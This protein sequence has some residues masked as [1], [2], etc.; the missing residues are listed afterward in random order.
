VDLAVDL[1][2]GRAF[3]K[4]QQRTQ[5]GR[6]ATNPRHAERETAQA[7]DVTRRTTEQMAQV[8]RTAAAEG[9]RTTRA[10]SEATLHNVEKLSQTWQSGSEAASRIVG[11]S[12]DQLSK[13]LGLSGET[14]RRAA[15]QSSGNLQAIV[16]G[17]SI[18]ADGF[19]NVSGEWIRFTQNWVEQNLENLDHLRECR[20]L[21][22]C[23][24]LQTQM[25]RENLEAVLH[26]TRRTSELA[27]KMADEAIRRI[28]EPSIAPR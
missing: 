18:I 19:S 17:S 3:F 2:G 26:S 1:L 14:A 9:E 27:V 8:S 28:G 23:M 15:Q 11:R 6:M 7:E 4:Q 12:V 21:Q 13:M 25:V 16:E 24:T 10:S 5:G 20:T 22:D